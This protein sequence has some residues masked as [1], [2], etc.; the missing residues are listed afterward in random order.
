MNLPKFIY[1]FPLLLCPSSIAYESVPPLK[2]ASGSTTFT[3]ISN[4]YRSN[5]KAIKTVTAA[6]YGTSVD[7]AA[8]NAAENAL[9]QV[10]GS[11][12]DAET[13]IKKQTEIRDG[14]ISRT[15]VIKKDIKDYSQGS[16]KYFEILDIQKNGSIYNVIARVDIRVEDFKEYIKNYHTSKLIDDSST[17]NKEIIKTIDAKGIG[18]SVQA[19]IQNAVENALANVVGS[20][21]DSETKILNQKEIRA[22]IIN[23]TKIIKKDR[24]DYAQG[25]IKYFEILDIKK[26]GSIYNISARIDVRVEDLR[27]YMKKLASEKVKIRNLNVFTS[28]ATD[29][30]N[31]DQKL[32]FL[33]ENIY[34]PLVSG[35]VVGI[36]IGESQRIRDLNLSDVQFDYSQKDCNFVDNNGVYSLCNSPLYELS[37]WNMDSTIIVPV[38]LT[39]NQ[40]FQKNLENTLDN[41]S[42]NKYILK[43]KR[44]KNC[45]MNYFLKGSGLAPKFEEWN[46]SSSND[47]SIAL[48][49]EDFARLSIYHLAGIRRQLKERLKGK[50]HRIIS[51][52]CEIFWRNYE[53]QR[54]L[55]HSLLDKNGNEIKHKKISYFNNQKGRP[56]DALYTCISDKWKT[57]IRPIIYSKRHYFLLIDLDSGLLSRLHDLSIEYV[58]GDPYH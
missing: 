25:S 9:T 23:Q 24:R 56:Y 47:Y 2:E 43:C 1:L 42:D 6:G 22:G 44:N 15:R 41:I 40:N 3:Q 49:S 29:L 34:S 48:I 11:F 16:I 4:S 5:K 20:F 57:G 12:I 33:L 21:I 36:K 58:D 35:E 18:K 8:Q 39:L 45:L 52:S 27:H 46:Y 38:T 31:E 51:S 54:F 19:A 7:A 55:S 50:F 30:N 37:K 13:Q 10:V 26:K 53:E 17:T 28:V 32:D 14:V